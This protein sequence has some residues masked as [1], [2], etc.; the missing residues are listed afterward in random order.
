LCAQAPWNG[1][2]AV[3]IP[4]HDGPA[5]ASF[6][7]LG[8]VRADIGAGQ[9]WLRLSVSETVSGFSLLVF[10]P[11]GRLRGQYWGKQAAE[12]LVIT[13]E[14]GSSSCAT[15]P[16]PIL[17][18]EW[19]VEVFGVADSHPLPWSVTV[20]CGT[21]PA[22]AD[23]LPPV[24][25][26]PWTQGLT[27]VPV[28]DRERLARVVRRTRAWYRGDFHAHTRASDGH[29]S[30]EALT[31]QATAR[32]LDF[33]AVTEHNLLST[34]HPAADVLIVPGTEVTSPAGHF[35]AL[36]I[37]R[38]LDWRPQAGDGGC[39]TGP[40]MTRLMRD[41][42]EQC[43]VV[44]VNHPLLRP[45]AWDW[46]ETPLDAIDALEIWN[47]PTY[48]PN[49][50]VLDAT[51]ALWTRLWDDGHRVV[52]LG[53]SDTH[54][55]P[56]DRYVPG[57]PPSVVGDPWTAVLADGLSVSAVVDAVR[58]G[59]VCV[60]RGPVLQVS[61]AVNGRRWPPG[62]SLTAALAGRPPGRTRVR[63]AA[64]VRQAPAGASVRWV[65][66]GGALLGGGDVE[67]MWEAG[68]WRWARAEVRDADG[69]LLAVSNP[70]SAGDGARRLRVWEDL[71][72]GAP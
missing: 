64:R 36:G 26:V 24:G 70:V 41:T 11:R 62:A 18:G 22:P 40:G 28:L 69:A 32:G 35:N 6:G 52:A 7:P 42:R 67:C 9:R 45:W 61:A 59:R 8:V 44:S 14:A 49:A 65:G 54:L 31:R 33:L 23:T 17:E 13:T 25:A 57:G 55:K 12:Q 63:L 21:G 66:N 16:G 48:P 5:V 43:G 2:A 34:G 53:G 19:R 68:A 38:W 3:S 20:E 4:R 60:S 1:W 58:A 39:A 46:P 72:A 56:S 51:L 50:D 30:A 27:S 37:R 29:Q 15:V 10:D 47:D 71:L